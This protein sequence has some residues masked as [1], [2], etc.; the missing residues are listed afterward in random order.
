[1]PLGGSRNMQL[2]G[3]NSLQMQ[4]SQSNQVPRKGQKYLNKFACFG[5]FLIQIGGFFCIESGALFK[6]KFRDPALCPQTQLQFM[7]SVEFRQFSIRQA[8]LQAN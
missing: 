4:S 2:K 5:R 7:C 8:G 3:P 1:M 6:H